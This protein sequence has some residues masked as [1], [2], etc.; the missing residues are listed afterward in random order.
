MALAIDELSSMETDLLAGLDLPLGSLDS[1]LALLDDVSEQSALSPP[2][3]PPSSIREDD[4]DDAGN[5][6][7]GIGF[8]PL[9]VTTE[10]LLASE[11]M[12]LPEL[13]APLLDT[14]PVPQPNPAP[15]TTATLTYP[16][17]A[18]YQSSYAAPSTHFVET[19]AANPSSPQTHAQTQPTQ[20]TIGIPYPA[21]VTF[22]SARPTQYYPSTIR[23][24]TTTTTTSSVRPVA[25]TSTTT[26]ASA[27]KRKRKP[28]KEVDPSTL[29]PSE[30]TELQAKRERR[31]L[32]NRESASA[33][34]Q[35]KKAYLDGLEQ[36]VREKTEETAALKH[37]VHVLEQQVQQLRNDNSSM[38]AF[39]KSQP[40]LLS[41]FLQWRARA[42]TMSTATTSLMMVT[43]LCFAFVAMPGL[44][45]NAHTQLSTP[46]RDSAP[47]F[48]SRTLQS[49]PLLPHVVGSD[50]HPRPAYPLGQAN[51]S[52]RSLPPDHLDKLLYMHKQ[53]LHT[54]A[55][56]DG[57][58]ATEVSLH[59]STL[60][61]APVLKMGSSERRA[62][63]ESTVVKR[64]SDTSYIFCTEVQILSAL[65]T[66]E[67]G[68]RPRLSLVVPTTTE[69]QLDA[70]STDS[71]HLMQIDCEVLNTRLIPTENATVVH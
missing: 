61:E 39:M 66:P 18:T 69:Q 41:Q 31:M 67:D 52:P 46:L 14:A 17:P 24:P 4:S 5:S 42:P 47:G 56:D 35:R 22:G 55:S 6:E 8:S 21:G 19:H 20:P 23:G 15:T 64:K 29:S 65:E 26:S 44:A 54:R 9:D 70:G 30:A 36:T 12:M 63:H 34:R 53:A 28:K 25:P 50:V 38:D 37:K 48:R 1:P 49:V 11:T 43:L 13:G 62:M 68:Q 3:T 16:T 33:S 2:F 60:A 51:P 45:P 32:K 10:E 71:A 40:Y 27:T 57:T 58:T 59:A 7:A